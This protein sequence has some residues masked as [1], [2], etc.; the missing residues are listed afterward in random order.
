MNQVLQV[1]SGPCRLFTT[2]RA[3]FLLLW[4]VLGALAPA[5]GRAG[6]LY[7]IPADLT[8]AP[9]NCTMATATIYDCN[10]NVSLDKDSDLSLTSNIM[11]RVGGSFT[12][13]KNL[14]TINNGKSFQL[15]AGGNVTMQKDTDIEMAIT[16]GGNMSF[17]KN[18]RI[19]GELQSGGNM[20]FAK[21][22]TI[23]GNLTVGG[24]LTG[25]K[26]VIVNGTCTVSGTKT[27]IT[28]TGGT[29]ALH[30]VRVTHNG[31][32]NTC[33]KTSV[34]I[35]ACNS[36]DSNG[37]CTPYTGGI[38]GTL[39]AESADGTD[40][41]TTNFVIA[42]GTSSTNRELDII[43]TA[44]DAELTFTNINKV[45]SSQGSC[46]NTNISQADCTL[47]V[48]SCGIHH[49]RLDHGGSGVTCVPA[50]VTVNACSGADSGSSCAAST[51]GI[52]GN[53][54]AKT[55]S[56]S[57]LAT[58]PFSIPSGQ[59]SQ[60]ISV[61]VTSAQTATFDTASLSSTPANS[62]T[63]WN[64]SSASC[65]YVFADSGFV[66]DI[67]NHVAGTTQ[68]ATF[69]A[70]KKADNSNACSPTLPD[71]TYDVDFSCSYSEPSTGTMSVTLG[72]QALA[73]SGATSKR[74]LTFASGVSSISASYPDA[75]EV[76]LMASYTG[77]NTGTIAGS[78]L[79]IAAPAKFVISTSS[80]SLR[81]GHTFNATV[82]A[83]NANNA[84]TTNFGSRV[85]DH[86]VSLTFSQCG[87]SAT[88]VYGGVINSSTGVANMP[89]FSKGVAV[90]AIASNFSYSE[91]GKLDATATMTDSG[92]ATPSTYMNTG[93]TVSG[94]TNT[95][96]GGACSGSFGTFAP[97]YFVTSLEPTTTKFAYSGVPFKLRVTGKNRTGDTTQNY[98]S[99][100]ARTVNLSAVTNTGTA[101]GTTVG[102]LTSTAIAPSSFGAGGGYADVT[103]TFT[104]PAVTG[105]VNGTKPEPQTIYI[106]AA[107]AAPGV[108]TSAVTNTNA[109]AV[110]PYEAKVE[111][112]YGRLRL[113]NVYGSS[114]T[115][116]KM[117]VQAEYWTKAK[118]WVVNG[119]DSSTK[120]PAAAIG[121]PSGGTVTASAGSSSDITLAAGKATIAVSNSSANKTKGYANVSVHLGNNTSAVAT[122]KVNNSCITAATGLTGADLLGLRSYNGCG[123]GGYTYDPAARAYFGIQSQ[124]TKG[125]VHVRE[126]FN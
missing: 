119:D 38:S 44:Q 4:M 82:T 24:N 70:V 14:T 42:S 108:T 73:C 97:S 25:A 36:A 21:D 2:M 84:T 75:G 117:P 104:F 94:T 22:T 48:A 126:V 99:S 116:L 91:A 96:T 79:F 111:V 11:L 122:E 72:N 23:N 7:S 39:V 77:A 109:N 65:D 54:V 124:E 78:D 5:P 60:T 49:L 12:S 90:T 10:G 45:T 20:T 6:T 28:C 18:A 35:T 100:V 95:E 114:L 58:V 103:P 85:N 88:G 47:P 101:I 74:S 32:A 66:F 98:T 34:T 56:G 121:F 118:V 89:A 31:S 3:L 26:N 68:T 57:V 40:L 64:G 120:I 125:V 59:S 9:F 107:E 112:R 1:E 27:N 51:V 83:V 55:A 50:A 86:R 33:A 92:Y 29:A 62:R 123:D 61:P 13:Q 93:L 115:S 8:S 87:G 69:Q 113:F 43:T 105:G 71:G 110:P 37:S 17:A 53:V 76:K 81:A 52:S 102:T 67:P 16:A 106:R 63:C 30:H 15:I 19:D 80:T 41:A 46:W